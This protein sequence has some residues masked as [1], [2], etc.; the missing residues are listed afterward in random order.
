VFRFIFP[1]DKQISKEVFNLALPVIVSNLSRV[2]MSMVDV[3]MVGRLGAEA[4]AATGMGA[5]LFWGALSFVLGIRTGV[6]TLV[7]RRLGQ[8]IDKECGT[9]LHNGLFMATLYA[10]P[11]S[12]AGWLWAKDII[13]FFIQDI[14][15]TRLATDYTSIVFIS[16]LFSAYSFVFQGF[17]TGVEKTKVH[18]NVTVTSNAINVYFNAGL[19]YGSDGVTQFFADTIP[20]LSF[21]SKLWQWTT[22]PAMGVKGAAIA[23]LIASTWMAVH[24]FSFLFSR[25]IKDR[26]SVFSLSTDRTMMMRQLKLALPQGV[27]ETVIAV[28]WSVFYKIMGMIGLIELATTE[29]LFTIMHASFMPA[30][31]VGQACATL[32]GKY[33][34]EKKIHK[35]EASIK[36]SI[37]LSVY[38]MGTMGMSFILIPEYYLFLFTDDPEI[39]RM[40]VFGLRMIGAV[41][42]LD[43]IGF[44][45]WF[46]LSG[47][48]NTLFPAVVESCLTWGVIVL[49]SYV[50]GVVLNLG[51]K[52]PWLLFPV[53]MGLFAGI[54]VWKI[55]KG[56]WKEIEV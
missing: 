16:L 32:V 27:Q 46:A 37:R 2:L 5:M 9:A 40:G 1:Q 34:G 25:Q 3:A 52:A 22:F 13:P 47:A 18:M 15:A 41:Q 11:I 42:F 51:F 24:Y 19:I 49:G 43:A 21:L 26:F 54:M 31:G 23:T 20:S 29:L 14:T 28:G 44:T 30:L 38:I 45:L 7:S 35:S 10:L 56:D 6:Q 12:L 17:F 8:K 33:M 55:S 48:G 50:F 39:I 36:E 4:L 53:Y